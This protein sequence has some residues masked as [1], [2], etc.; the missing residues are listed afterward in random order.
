MGTSGSSGG[1]GGGTPLVPSWLDDGPGGPLP[2]GDGNAP[3]AEDAGTAPADE[4]AGGDAQGAP[5][6]L[7]PI[8][9]VPP[10]A[11]FQSAR[12]NFSAFAGSGGGNGRALRRAARDYVRSGAGSSRNATRRMGA[13]RVAAGGALGIF[14]GFQRD[15]T[16]ATLRRLNLGNL[17]GL[18]PV[19]VFLGLTEVV[20]PDGG[21][22]D[23]GVLLQLRAGDFRMDGL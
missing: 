21:S 6:T 4:A 18:P 7:P 2:G 16:D 14:R 1:P 9:P 5:A 10:P 3:P 11:R 13:S 23:E 19:D 20:C 22:I 17:I 8:P 12:R 15:G